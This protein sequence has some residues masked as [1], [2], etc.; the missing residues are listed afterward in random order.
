MKS[1]NTA[2]PKGQSH[3]LEGLL[4]VGNPAGYPSLLEPGH[5]PASWGCSESLWSFVQFHG[6]PI[7]EI[8]NAPERSSSDNT[9]SFEALAILLSCAFELT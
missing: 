7:A 8:R 6:C 5:L 9:T 1:A 4:L 2:T 3:P